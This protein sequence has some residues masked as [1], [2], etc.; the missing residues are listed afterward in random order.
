MAC[1]IKRNLPRVGY[2]DRPCPEI[3]HYYSEI[4]LEETF[5]K[6]TA[7]PQTPNAQLWLWQT[8]ER[9]T[10]W[11]SKSRAGRELEK[12]QLA[13][14]KSLNKV[15]IYLHAQKLIFL[16]H[17]CTSTHQ[18]CTKRQPSG[19][20]I[21][22]QKVFLI[23]AIGVF[24]S[25]YRES[26]NSAICKISHKFAKKKFLD[27]R[28]HILNLLWFIE[29]MLRHSFPCTWTHIF[30]EHLH[31]FSTWGNTRTHT[32]LHR[33]A[34]PY[35]LHIIVQLLTN[36]LSLPPSPPPPPAVHKLLERHHR[37]AIFFFF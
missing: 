8:L 21:G 28:P 7:E 11:M 16:A 36:Q 13:H 20:C 32:C 35:I 37:E 12:W 2:F 9:G 4:V 17:K 29:K 6:Y 31:K 25:D 22:W 3:A 24:R 5:L 1:S 15:P 34:Q 27:S 19:S 23:L 10:K 33:T 30:T 14:P 18:L 26:L